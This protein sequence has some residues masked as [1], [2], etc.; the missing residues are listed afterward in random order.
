MVLDEQAVFG[1]I[2]DAGQRC[3]A[4]RSHVIARAGFGHDQMAFFEPTQGLGDRGDRDLVV[5]SDFTHGWQTLPRL[6]NLVLHQFGQS[7]GKLCIQRLLRGC[8][9][10]EHGVIVLYSID[11]RI[12]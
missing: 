4:W 2:A 1:R 8:G 3:S 11:F 10:G 12:L 5:C 6:E 7:L 9:L